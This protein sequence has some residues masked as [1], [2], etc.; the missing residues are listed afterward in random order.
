MPRCLAFPSPKYQQNNNNNHTNDLD[1][2]FLIELEF[3]NVGFEERGKPE[4]P[5]KKPLGAKERTNNKQA[6]IQDFEMG[7]EFL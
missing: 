4:Y 6:R 5:E 7:G 3:E 2:R 1:T